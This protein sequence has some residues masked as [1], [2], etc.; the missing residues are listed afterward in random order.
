MLIF[1]PNILHSFGGY[2]FK[3]VEQKCGKKGSKNTGAY[4]HEIHPQLSSYFFAPWH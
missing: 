3:S 2:P 1:S 4:M